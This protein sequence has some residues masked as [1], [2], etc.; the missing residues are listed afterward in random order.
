MFDGTKDGDNKSDIIKEE[1]S[2]K[3]LTPVNEQTKE[4]EISSPKSN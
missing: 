1:R 3:E 2:E 4:R